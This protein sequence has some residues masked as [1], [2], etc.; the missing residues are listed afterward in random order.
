M[1]VGV[2]VGNRDKGLKWTTLGKPQALHGPQYP[3]LQGKGL[4]PNEKRGF[5]STLVVSW[6]LRCRARLGVG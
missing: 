6:E 3:G 2:C 1:G 4:H 5:G